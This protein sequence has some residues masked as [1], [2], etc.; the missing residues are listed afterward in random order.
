MNEIRIMKKAAERVKIRDEAPVE[1]DP[2]RG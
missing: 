1:V 2:D